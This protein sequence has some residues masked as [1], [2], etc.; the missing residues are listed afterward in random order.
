ML[1]PSRAVKSEPGRNS[2]ATNSDL[3]H[4]AKPKFRGMVI[5][6]LWHWAVGQDNPFNIDEDKMTEA[7]A[8][9]WE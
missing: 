3:L 1:V 2:K 4:G 6:T 9:I 8:I 5:Q 7:L